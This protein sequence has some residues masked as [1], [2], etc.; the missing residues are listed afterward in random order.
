[1][2][3]E[4]ARGDECETG[5]SEGE[6]GMRGAEAILRGFNLVEVLLE[7]S[8][9]PGPT[10]LHQLAHEAPL[11]TAQADVQPK[12]AA[13]QL[14]PVGLLEDR[15]GVPVSES[16]GMVTDQKRAQQ[17]VATSSQPE[18][19]LPALPQDSGQQALL[20]SQQDMDCA[21][22][23]QESS[24]NSLDNDPLPT[25]PQAD[26]QPSARNSLLV[27]DS[28]ETISDADVNCR[29]D[30]IQA[31]LQPG[32][33]P[34]LRSGIQA[35]AASAISPEARPL[36]PS[37]PPPTWTVTKKRSAPHKIFG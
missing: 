9:K 17:A 7:G 22:E 32:D 11:H 12:L 34:R 2:C 6:L 31:S 18:E 15:L 29:A 4:G 37:S 26:D 1:M 30:E 20:A 16:S 28:E 24:A 14:P 35:E 5:E 13:A 27:P 3:A 21:G 10:E 33:S 23:Q 8:D 36:A 19:Q 25:S